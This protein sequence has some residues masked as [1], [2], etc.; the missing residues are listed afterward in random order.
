MILR[1][2]YSASDS[3]NFGRYTL[4]CRDVNFREWL[5]GEKAFRRSGCSWKC[6]E[7]EVKIGNNFLG[8]LNVKV[9]QDEQAEDTSPVQRENYPPYDLIFNRDNF[10]KKSLTR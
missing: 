6:L 5:I 3:N 10:I 9:P 4:T 1:T 7:K 2:D 8:R